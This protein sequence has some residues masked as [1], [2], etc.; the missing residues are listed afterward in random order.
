[1]GSIPST[2]SLQSKVDERGVWKVFGKGSDR[3]HDFKSLYLSLFAL[4]QTDPIGTDVFD[5][6]IYPGV[7]I[8]SG[9]PKL[10]NQPW[11]TTVSES[12]SYRFGNGAPF[13]GWIVQE[14][15]NCCRKRKCK[16]LDCEQEDPQQK[17]DCKTYYEAWKVLAGE[18]VPETFKKEEFNDI[19]AFPPPNQSCGSFS[20]STTIR[21]FYAEATDPTGR[22]RVSRTIGN[23][24]KGTK[25]EVCG[26]SISSGSLK[27]T[28]IKPWFW[29]NSADEFAV[30]VNSKRSL[31]ASWRCCGGADDGITASTTVS[32]GRLADK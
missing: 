32:N 3:V 7:D 23:W 24:G 20:Q 18:K 9:N 5:I 11:G 6:R 4:S 27:S 2:S 29:E 22:A 21:F 30:V 1:M 28:R 16:C 14:V 13:I 19:A 8:T 26:V 12:D 10:G 25:V 31:N 17:D 15:V